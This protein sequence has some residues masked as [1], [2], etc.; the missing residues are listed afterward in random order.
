MPAC[1]IY[2]RK[3]GMGLSAQLGHT[4]AQQALWDLKENSQK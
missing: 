2:L 4:A 3:K 1:F